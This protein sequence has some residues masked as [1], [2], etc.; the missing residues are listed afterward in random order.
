MSLCIYTEMLVISVLFFPYWCNCR[1][2]LYLG[3]DRDM[4]LFCCWPPALSLG[5]SVSSHFVFHSFWNLFTLDRKYFTP[6]IVQFLA[7]KMHG[8]R[9]QLYWGLD[10]DKKLFCCWPPALSIGQSVKK[11]VKWISFRA[12]FFLQFVYSWSEIF[13]FTHRCSN[14]SNQMQFKTCIS[15]II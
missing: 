14:L 12:K 9:G 10:R 5:Q 3:L 15:D 7:I 11:S 4:K 1:R 13:R 6:H 2:F 8:H